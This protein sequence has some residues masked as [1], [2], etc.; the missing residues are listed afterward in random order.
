[1]TR[2]PS[3]QTL[4]EAVAGSMPHGDLLR[5]V[6]LRRLPDLT[7]DIDASAGSQTDGRPD[8]SETPQVDAAT[9]PV[10]WLTSDALHLELSQRLV[11][12]AT[13]DLL[14]LCPDLRG[15]TAALARVPAPDNGGG[16]PRRRCLVAEPAASI[17][18]VRR[19]QLQGAEVAVQAGMSVETL[20]CDD[21]TALVVL[22]EG[23]DRGAVLV[24][25]PTLVRIVRQWAEDLWTRSTSL[26][27]PG[28]EHVARV[29]EHPTAQLASGQLPQTGPPTQ[30]PARS[31]QV[32]EHLAAGMKD[33]AIGRAMG[34]SART[35][36]RRVAHLERCFG[37][38]NRIQLVARAAT[39]GW[40]TV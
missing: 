11:E 34:I 9:V 15:C 4:G 22:G 39:Q 3:T 35:V 37:A 24:H 1:M 31:Q 36:R 26:P 17:T 33:E 40:V 23:A 20:I 16:R 19:L 13:R 5:S 8:G 38:M 32:L 2:Y 14:H 27:V 18:A 25:A 10:E 30:L 29:L 7:E 6:V 21:R 28:R 12:S